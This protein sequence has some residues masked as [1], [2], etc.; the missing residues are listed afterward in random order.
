M[1]E[2]GAGSSSNAVLT[3]Q[4]RERGM[5]RIGIE[6]KKLVG[7]VWEA[8]NDEAELERLNGAPQLIKQTLLLQDGPTKKVLMHKLVRPL[9]TTRCGPLRSRSDVFRGQYQNF[10]EVWVIACQALEEKLVALLA[11]MTDTQRRYLPGVVG[12]TVRS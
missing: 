5:A 9:Y 1:E 11:R 8:D 6:L 10:Q 12:I 4:Q 2:P 3:E 7:S